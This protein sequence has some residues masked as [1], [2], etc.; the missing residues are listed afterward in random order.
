MAPPNQVL[1]NLLR[2]GMEADFPLPIRWLSPNVQRM[3]QKIQKDG[4][5][6]PAWTLGFYARTVA[7]DL[8]AMNPDKTL[9][10]ILDIAIQIDKPGCHVNQSTWLSLLAQCLVRFP[11]RGWGLPQR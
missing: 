2:R 7:R 10:R 1:L 8:M 9:Q 5:E 4:S 6:N 11:A 3:V